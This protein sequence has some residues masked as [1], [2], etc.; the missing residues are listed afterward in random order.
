MNQSSHEIQQRIAQI[1][2]ERQ[3]AQFAEQQRI[4]G[5]QA[6]RQKIE[7]ANSQLADLRRQQA[8]A[9]LEEAKTAAAGTLAA[10]DAAVDRLKPILKEVIKDIGTR[11]NLLMDKIEDT[12]ISHNR[13]LEQA[14][15]A[16]ASLAAEQVQPDPVYSNGSAMMEARQ[17]Q[18]IVGSL[19]GGIEG[20][21]SVYLAWAEIIAEAPPNLKQF[22]QGI[23][24]MY[25]G[26]LIEPGPDATRHTLRAQLSNDVR[27]GRNPNF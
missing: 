26:K 15:N 24:F 8:L 13:T 21:S 6:E 22:Y 3:R 19:T 23:A 20:A 5:E 7:Q 11:L 16:A 25:T 10:N 2:Q 17:L 12:Y 4:A 27:R 9:E 1:E 18:H 14:Q